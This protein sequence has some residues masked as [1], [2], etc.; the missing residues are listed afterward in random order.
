M[1]RLIE[2]QEVENS[3]P[4]HEEANTEDL[5]S[6]HEAHKQTQEAPLGRRVRKPP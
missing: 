6:N 4:I 5:A 3:N 2:S 1:N